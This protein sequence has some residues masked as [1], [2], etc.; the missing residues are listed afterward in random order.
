MNVRYYRFYRELSG[1][2]CFND[3]PSENPR[4]YRMFCSWIRSEWNIYGRYWL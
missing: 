2:C 3:R 1:A 4:A